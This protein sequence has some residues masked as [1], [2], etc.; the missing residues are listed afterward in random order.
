L[1]QYDYSLYR[2]YYVFSISGVSIL[3]HN[4]NPDLSF[5]KFG[6][7]GGEEIT[8]KL[9][10]EGE[11]QFIIEKKPIELDRFEMNSKLAITLLL[12][13]TAFVGLG[14]FMVVM[15]NFDCKST[16]KIDKTWCNIT[17]TPATNQ[18]FLLYDIYGIIQN[19]TPIFCGTGFCG[20]NQ[21]ISCNLV[22][23]T[24][25]RG[26]LSSE[27]P[28]KPKCVNSTLS[29]IGLIMILLASLAWISV[30]IVDCN[31]STTTSGNEERRLL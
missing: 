31:F 25:C 5:S 9:I 1:Y 11:D 2:V 13:L 4:R 20:L 10:F 21:S 3:Y 27:S 17:D 24:Y 14:I 28:C 15:G 8:L 7:G 30:L 29:I 16:I 6:K 19:G 12:V 23:N 22:N 26:V 18:S